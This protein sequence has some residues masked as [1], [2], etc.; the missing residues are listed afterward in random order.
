MEESASMS[1]MLPLTG[2]WPLPSLATKSAT[3]RAMKQNAGDCSASTEATRL[4]M[5]YMFGSRH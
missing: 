1:G 5:S 4:G 3:A 2:S